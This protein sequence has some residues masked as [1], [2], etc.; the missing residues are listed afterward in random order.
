MARP[1][2]RRLESPDNFASRRKPF[3]QSHLA[4]G[5]AGHGAAGPEITGRSR[6]EVERATFV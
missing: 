4:P 3:I 1:V 5:L 6:A 2:K